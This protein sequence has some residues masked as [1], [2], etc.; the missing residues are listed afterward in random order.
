MT[1]KCQK[2]AFRKHR[3]GVPVLA[4]QFKNQTSVHENAGS[5]PGLTQLVKGPCCPGCDVGPKPQL[6]FDS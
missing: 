1:E 5:I 6:Q 2:L 3:R 4:Q